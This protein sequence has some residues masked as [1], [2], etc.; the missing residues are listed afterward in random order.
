MRNFDNGWAAF[1]GF[2]LAAVIVVPQTRSQ[3][4]WLAPDHEST[5]SIEAVKPF[6]KDDFVRDPLFFSSA[7]NLNLRVPVDD[8]FMVVA[9][10]PL[11]YFD[12]KDS[13]LD[14]TVSL[15]NPYLG[16]EVR[17]N[18]ELFFGELG[19]RFPV[20]DASD[21]GIV[22]GTAAD[23]AR[24][25]AYAID[26]W[27]IGVLGN[28][29]YRPDPSSGVMLRAR[30]GPVFSIYSGDSEFVD[31]SEAYLVYGGQVWF[32]YQR[33]SGAM[34]LFART[35]VSE[36]DVDNRTLEHLGFTFSVDATVVRPGLQLHIPMDEHMRDVAGVAIGLHL[37]VPFNQ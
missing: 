31:N 29:Q 7:L 36:S 24:A 35:W 28:L 32:T 30:F 3:S 25:D 26:Q 22:S 8:R 10:V 14:N 2:V 9:E 5:V 19:V 27:C 37:T 23:Y 16:M 12:V 33:F 6:F 4:L 21:N 13:N 20:V 1:I 18:T 34:G 17:G 11:S 15:G